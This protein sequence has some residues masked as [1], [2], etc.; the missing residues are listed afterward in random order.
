MAWVEGAKH[1]SVPDHH[2]PQAQATVVMTGRVRVT[3]PEGTHELSAGQALFI[4]GG[5]P[6][7]AEITADA[8]YIDI[9][10]PPREGLDTEADQD[11]R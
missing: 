2:H 1:A 4:P 8:V 9:F 11:R 5:T 3:T 6:H 7:S 10:H